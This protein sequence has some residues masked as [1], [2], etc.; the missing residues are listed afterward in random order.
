MRQ[1]RRQ[2][3]SPV[4][5]QSEPTPRIAIPFPGQQAQKQEEAHETVGPPGDP[6]NRFGKDRQSQPDEHSG[7]SKKERRSQAAQEQKRQEP[8]GPMKRQIGEM[9]PDRGRSPQVPVH[10]QTGPKQGPVKGST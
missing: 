6:C 4:N 7:Y 10:Y 2:G 8:V 9:I 1:E 5:E 3:C